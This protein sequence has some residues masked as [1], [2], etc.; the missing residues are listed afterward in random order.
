MLWLA[1]TA[2][3]S[4]IKD[5]AL[6]LGKLL[7]PAYFKKSVAGDVVLITGAGSGLGRILAKKMARLGA[8][9][10]C[11]DINKAENDK[12]VKMMTVNGL[13]AFGF[14][15]D[16]SDREQV[17]KMA[18]EVRRLVGDVSILVNNAGIA[19]G[20]YLLD[21]PDERIQKTFD[22]NV[23]AHF[24]TIKAFLP[25]MMEMGK[26]HIVTVA[27][28]AGM[29]GTCRLADYCSSKFANMGMDESLRHELQVLGFG[30]SIQ[31]TVVCPYYID[32][33]MFAGVRSSVL[34]IYEPEQVVDLMLDGI[35]LN[36]M[37]VL[38]PWYFRFLKAALGSLPREAYFKMYSFFG[39]DTGLDKAQM[40]AAS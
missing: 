31:T 3:L 17:Y 8:V 7:A 21:T 25:R 20:Q 1:V 30:H 36:K 29:Q 19:N 33:G 40:R 32:T 10:V 12:T 24:W 18:S 4:I 22:V 28:I 35:L 14:Q 13:R 6:G 11:V 34:P 23:L 38:I 2:L 5:T 26:G 37:I 39:A 16:V 27:S 15:C 9:V